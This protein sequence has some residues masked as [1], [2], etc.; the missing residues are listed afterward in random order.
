MVDDLLYELY[1]IVYTALE[2]I[3]YY[4]FHYCPLHYQLVYFWF[5]LLYILVR[6]RRMRRDAI[7]YFDNSIINWI[8]LQLKKQISVYSVY[9]FLKLSI[10]K[11]TV[12]FTS[13][14]IAE[15]SL[16]LTYIFAK[17]TQLIPLKWRPIFKK[18]SYFGLFSSIRT[19]W[20]KK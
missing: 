16:V 12:F 14:K 9:E 13:I 4:G 17:I 19:K 10:I 8:F 15:L 1:G 2:F 6:R 18:I 5:P 7:T 20:F 11:I 3:V